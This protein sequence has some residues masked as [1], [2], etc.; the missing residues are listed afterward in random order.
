MKKKYVKP[1]VDEIKF[2]LDAPIMDGGDIFSGTTSVE[3]G[4]SEQPN[5]FGK[6]GYQ[7][8]F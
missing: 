2:Q 6:S 1:D 7:N 4:T 3:P 5:P 8:N